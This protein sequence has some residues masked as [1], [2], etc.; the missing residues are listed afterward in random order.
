MIIIS[1]H[2]KYPKLSFIFILYETIAFENNIILEI[3]TI[4]YVNYTLS[5]RYILFTL[6]V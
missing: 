4:I 2:I 1:K 3:N 5:N 6:K